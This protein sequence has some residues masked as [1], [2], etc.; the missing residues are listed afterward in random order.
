MFFGGV[1]LL[2]WAA[3]NRRELH[4]RQ[5]PHS[6]LPAPSNLTPLLPGLAPHQPSPASPPP[7]G[8]SSAHPPA[9]PRAAPHRLSP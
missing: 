5:R 2:S 3:D 4:E 6:P 1:A 9:P 7:P 8:P